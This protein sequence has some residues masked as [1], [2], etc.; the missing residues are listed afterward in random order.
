MRGEKIM[1]VENVKAEEEKE[2]NI[3]TSEGQLKKYLSSAL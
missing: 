2:K 3:A 1:A